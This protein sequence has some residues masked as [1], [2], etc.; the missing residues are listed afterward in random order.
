MNDSQPPKPKRRW[1]RFS[2]LT[3]LI[4]VLACAA[5]C[6]F[7]ISKLLPAR[8]QRLAVT[9]IR[10]FGGSIS[11]GFGD[12]NAKPWAAEVFGDDFY[13]VIGV[14][15]EH[16]PVTDAGLEHLKTLT[17]LESLNLNSTKVTDAGMERLKKSTNLQSLRLEDTEVTDAGASG[18]RSALPNLSITPSPGQLATRSA[19]IARF[20][21][22]GG[23]FWANPGRKGRWYIVDLRRAK[24]SDA[25]L[26]HV[27]GLTHQQE[28]I[29]LILWDRQITDAGLKH[30]DGLTGLRRLCL[31]GTQVTDA[32]LEHLKGCNRLERLNLD[33]TRVTDAGLAHLKGLTGLQMLDLSGTQ[34][35][36]SGLEQIKGLTKLKHLRLANTQVS[37]EGVSKL[38]QA[39]PECKIIH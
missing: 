28:S 20:R 34:V 3:M 22:L 8:R 2:L 1:Y 13:P 5:C 4:A 24:V 11:Y 35:T 31:G 30:F 19:A 6:S 18:L 15:F 29:E 7:S 27:R 36:S 10:K 38:Q 26:V 21:N 25:D 33:Q 23:M 16:T 9:E 17:S 37:D 14:D 12:S 32:G 39:L